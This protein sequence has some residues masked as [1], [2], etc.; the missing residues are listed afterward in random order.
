MQQWTQ[1]KQWR[2][3]WT[4]WL[5]K[6]RTWQTTSGTAYRRVLSRTPLT[7]WKIWLTRLKKQLNMLNLYSIR[8]LILIIY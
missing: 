5:R 6:W 3:W 8:Y 2:T 7:M 4:T 1:H